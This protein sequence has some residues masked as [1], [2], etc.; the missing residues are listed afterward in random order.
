MNIVFN[1]DNNYAPYLATTILSI[2]KTNTSPI[3]FYILD[4]GISELSKDTIKKIVHLSRN[5]IEFIKIKKDELSDL[6]Q[7]I[8]YIPSVTYARLK[9]VDYLPLDVEKVI[10]LDTDILV[11]ASLQ[12]LWETDLKDN[13]IGACFDPFIEYD[14]E[15]YKFKIGLASNHY[16]VNAGVLLINL[17][18][19][20]STNIWE[21]SINF[22]K[23]FPY[24][25]Y[26]DQDIINFLFKGEI[27]YLDNRYNFS[28]N[29]K[30]KIKAK[31]K[32][33]TMHIHPVE[34][35]TMPIAIFHYVGPTKPW[36]ARCKMSNVVKFQQLFS[37][38]KT[39]P[40]EW[41]E[42]FELQTIRQK[43]RCIL[44]DIKEKYYYKIY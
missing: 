16:Y 37:E 18:K 35:T 29:H 2:I 7:T 32:D 43:I 5:T 31:K 24:A 21:K 40:P 13:W 36:H 11:N 14:K 34:K 22:F 30:N 17:T 27:V 15:N 4:L 10:Y 1:A 6:P 26:Q 38:I 9:I 8:T 20:R 3:N 44:K 41:Q 39:P 23:N 33:S 28:V 25:Q 42:K 12:P 19:W